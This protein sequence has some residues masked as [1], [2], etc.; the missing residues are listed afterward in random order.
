MAVPSLP[1]F[2][3]GCRYNSKSEFDDIIANDNVG[4]FLVHVTTQGMT[5]GEFLKDSR[6]WYLYKHGAAN[7]LSNLMKFHQKGRKT[8]PYVDLVRWALQEPADKT[9]Y[10]VLSTYLSLPIN[11]KA[12]LWNLIKESNM[13]EPTDEHYDSYYSRREQIKPF[14]NLSA[15][16]SIRLLEFLHSVN[17]EEVKDFRGSWTDERDGRTYRT[18]TINGKTWLA[19]NFKFKNSNG[20][21]DLEDVLY[22]DI[23][24]EG[25]HAPTPEEWYRIQGNVHVSCY[26][27]NDEE[28]SDFD[29]G[30]ALE[31]NEFTTLFDKEAWKDAVISKS[32]SDIPVFE[33]AI[34]FGI[35][36][37]HLNKR[38][39]GFNFALYWTDLGRSTAA[40]VVHN[41]FKDEETG[42][43]PRFIF[44]RLDISPTKKDADTFVLPS[45]TGPLGLGCIRLVKD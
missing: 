3:L 31:A 9:F 41:K 23:I 36:P 6:V 44:N 35:K 7:I 13:L 40:A 2:F 29:S 4:A 12:P 25:W 42:S 11:D 18:V 27:R 24:P 21:Y 37:T 15:K 28:Y 10:A 22:K 30:R 32:P 39:P 16:A 8:F 33:D 17:P 34:G 20:V 14:Y 43:E 26:K 1:R 5:P 38:F 19:E 45:K